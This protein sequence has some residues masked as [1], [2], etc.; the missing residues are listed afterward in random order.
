MYDA[1]VQA[2]RNVWYG[3]R[4]EV[5]KEHVFT[6]EGLAFCST[7]GNAYLGGPAGEAVLQ[8]GAWDYEN[9]RK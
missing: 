4:S 9:A 2:L 8:P 6:G 1:S 7:T 5:G 3:S